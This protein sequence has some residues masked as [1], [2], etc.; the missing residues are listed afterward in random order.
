MAAIK[1]TEKMRH[2]DYTA[3]RQQAAQLPVVENADCAVVAV[4]A[5][6]GVDYKTAH[7]ALEA[8]GRKPRKGTPMDITHAAL[9]DL[10]FVAVRVDPRNFIDQYPGAHK[11][12]RSVT[13]HHPARFGSV[14]TNGKTYLFRT[15][16]HILTV[17][18]G[19]NL[20]HTRGRACRVI[21]LYEVKRIS[22]NA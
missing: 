10:G 22:Q 7:A 5:A 2:S 17:R 3:I 12:L 18:N 16:G 8:R 4:A 20:D 14:W 13:T 9:R 1:Q 21:V 19:Q 11:N 15:R 6:T